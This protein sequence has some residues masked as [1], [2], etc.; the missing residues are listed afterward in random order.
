MRSVL[1]VAFYGLCLVTS[2]LVAC[3][4]SASDF[5]VQISARVR[6]QPPQIVL[7]W[8]PDRSGSAEGYTVYRRGPEGAERAHLGANGTV[9]WQ[10]EEAAA[11]K[12]RKVRRTS[13]R[14]PQN[15][16]DS[17]DF[18]SVKG[19]L[20][21]GEFGQFPGWGAGVMLPGTATNFVDTDVQGGITYEYQVVKS[22]AGYNG[23]GYLYAGI[24]APLVENRGRLLLVLDRTYVA[25]LA[26]ELAHLEQDLVG[27]GWLVT[28]I[29]VGRLD[30]VTSVKAKIHE[31]YAADPDETQAVFLFGHVPVPYS[32][33]IVPDGHAPDHEGAWPC[34]GYYG[35]M[36]G[37]WTDAI[38]ED[39]RA[40]DPRN[41]N[42][43]GDGKFDQS[44]F[45][46]PVK[47]MVG[48]V[49]LAN[50][51]GRVCAGGAATFPNELELLRNYL[52]KD[53]K[54]RT[55][56]FEVPRR[57]L[58]GDYFG[59]RDGEAFAASGWRNFASFFTASAIT[60]LPR[61]G[62]WIPTLHTNA[63]LWAYGCGNG[64][65]TSI[66]GL[67]NTAPYDDGITSELVRN[68]VKAVFTMLYG[69]WLGDWDSE[70]NLQRAALAMPS[71]CVACAL[72]GRPHWFLHHMAL[73]APIGYSTRLT[74]NNG[75]AG[76]YHNEV[77]S[78][79][80]QI[81]VALM[82]DPTL[83]LHPV[84]PPTGVAVEKTANGLELSWK[85]S[86]DQV[87]GYHV[88]RAASP[89]GPYDR[90]TATPIK[91]TKF[92]DRM[93]KPAGRR[94]GK[95]SEPTNAYYMVRA[96]K[97]ETSGSGTY[98]NPSQGAFLACCPRDT[99][100]RVEDERLGPTGANAAVK[101]NQVVWVDDALPN[102]AIAGADGGDGWGW[103]TN[104]PAPFSGRCAHQSAILPGLHEHY[105][106]WAAE[107]LKPGSNAE[108]FAYVYLDPAQPPSEIMLQWFEDSSWEHR[109]YWGAD[110]IHYGT[111]GTPGRKYMG[112]LPP[113]GQWVLLQIP[114]G[115][116]GLAGTTVNGM[117][118]TQFDG[119]AIWDHCG[120]S[121]PRLKDDP[122]TGAQVQTVARA[123]IAPEIAG[124]GKEAQMSRKAHLEA[125]APTIDPI[126]S[127]DES[128]PAAGHT[129]NGERRIAQGQSQVHVTNAMLDN[130]R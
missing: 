41:R 20:R 72:S 107:P 108:L 53:H 102:G 37:L 80:G 82:G 16:T 42:V 35:D 21:V 56:Q 59:S 111:A 95:S 7:S 97:L 15:Q 24:E 63:Y 52:D 60:G 23:F 43:P 130:A 110:R 120:L 68:D 125:G 85:A 58:V 128:A 46:A 87:L 8:P 40:R 112:P 88:Y 28:R 33:D 34:D 100:A 92:V 105:F 45:P 2:V 13:R 30:S 70:D 9:E 124:V 74:Q 71:Y 113:V 104:N 36:D 17:E 116:V 31:A 19:S 14:H 54:F 66:E 67:G 65:Y 121:E 79:A 25:E 114:A 29:E 1:N 109:A 64:T 27:D 106:A 86:R 3:A 126:P 38:V 5:A 93:V 98:Y 73:G 99:G 61:K 127:R 89:G 123:A 48:R 81:H 10:S 119:R 11:F 6:A 115:Q 75:P 4:E 94:A 96:I 18:A 103:I 76:L 44:C 26:G 84:A 129:V 50:L 83:R 57:A 39:T 69:S 62:T 101:T 77:N 118:F 90:L 47:L 55:G 49:D 91:M 122:Q 117:A 32:G 12:T 78:C 22:T 51:P